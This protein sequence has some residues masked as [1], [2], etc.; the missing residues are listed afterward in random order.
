MYSLFFT[1]RKNHLASSLQA[2][3]KVTFVLFSALVYVPE[4]VTEEEIKLLDSIKA[5]SLLACIVYIS[6]S[7]SDV[8]WDVIYVHRQMWR[9][10]DVRCDAIRDIR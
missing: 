6:L 10:Y 7:G 4:G 1:P 8:R 5:S 3:V 2:Y 9:N